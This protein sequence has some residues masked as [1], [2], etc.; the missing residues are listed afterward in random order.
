MSNTNEFS[1]KVAII[2]GSGQGMGKAVAQR[3]CQ[4]GASVII[5]DLNESSADQTAKALNENGFNA[6]AIQ[7][8]V[9][10]AQDVNRMIETTVKSYGEIH[11]LVNNACALR[12]TKIMDM[13]EEEWDFVVNANLK[14]TYLCSKAVL[15]IMQ[16]FSCIISTKLF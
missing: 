11:I 16:T 10:S 3:L 15:P 7:G 5:N 1:N 9:T 14:S 4:G 13:E 12:P 6:L 2:T 8:D